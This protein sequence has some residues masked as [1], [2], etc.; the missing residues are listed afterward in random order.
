MSKLQPFQQVCLAIIFMSIVSCSED[1]CSPNKK[2]TA[3]RMFDYG[4]SIN[5]NESKAE[6]STDTSFACLYP[7]TFEKRDDPF[8]FRALDKKNRD[9]QM[10]W[11]YNGEK[12]AVGKSWEVSL[13]DLLKEET[14][15]VGY[16]IENEF[17]VYSCLTFLEQ[18]TNDDDSDSDSDNE[19]DND[20][21]DDAPARPVKLKIVLD[22]GDVKALDEVSITDA[23]EGLDLKYRRSWTIDGK[24]ISSTNREF[25]YKFVQPGSHTIKLTD[26]M[27][28]ESTIKTI[29]IEA[30][31]EGPI[32]YDNDE[33]KG[34]KI[35]EECISQ[36]VPRTNLILLPQTDLVIDNIAI[37]SS[38]DGQVSLS[39]VG[40]DDGR[41]TENFDVLKGENKLLCYNLFYND[42]LKAGETYELVLT[43]DNPDKPLLKSYDSCIDRSG[44]NNEHLRVEFQNSNVITK[45]KYSFNE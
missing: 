27:T 43:S 18:P 4:I 15:S 29:Q 38:G 44:F 45:I 14:N 7:D 25:Q 21:A 28:G 10:I 3:I 5:N 40:L 2:G 16:C 39:I 11:Y 20:A 37:S 1:G 19:S 9:L 31:P 8:V 33:M 24:E 41:L 35:E 26:K 23:T 30:P 34:G 36:A 22:T 42:Y 32:F 13:N 17:C 12:V 6:Y